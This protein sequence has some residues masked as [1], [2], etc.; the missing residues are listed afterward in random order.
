MERSCRGGFKVREIRKGCGRLR[1]EGE[2]GK[3]REERRGL[4]VGVGSR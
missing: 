2:G 4:Y 3:R 1:G